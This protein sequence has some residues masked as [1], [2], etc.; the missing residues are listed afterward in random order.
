MTLPMISG[1]SARWF[2]N[3]QRQQVS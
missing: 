1:W 3:W 2:S